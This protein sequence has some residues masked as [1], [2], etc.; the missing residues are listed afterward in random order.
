LARALSPGLP[1]ESLEMGSL[2]VELQL[3]PV[4]G[5][6]RVDELGMGLEHQG[7]F[8]GDVGRENGHAGTA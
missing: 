8:R 4:L 1:G 7:S 2:G 5:D 3:A 6:Q